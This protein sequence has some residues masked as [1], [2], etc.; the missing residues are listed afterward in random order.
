MTAIDKILVFILL[1]A[2][3]SA[4]AKIWLPSYLSDNMVLQRNSNVNIWGWT[5]DTYT[6][7]TITVTGSWNQVPVTTVADQ[8]R[9]SA[10]LAT[11]AAGGPYNILI[12]AHDTI[13]L[14][15][16]MMGDVWICFGA[17]EY[18]MDAA[19]RGCCKLKKRSNRQT[20]PK[21]GFSSCPSTS[22]LLSRTIPRVI[23]QGARPQTMQNFSS[24]SLLFWPGVAPRTGHT[25]GP[26]LLQL[27]RNT[28]RN[29]D[30]GRADLRRPGIEGGSGS[31]SEVLRVAADPR[32]NF[33]RHD[34]PP[35]EKWTSPE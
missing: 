10:T 33:Q 17:I 8:G 2:W 34:P 30:S 13:R 6:N 31:T 9:W 20:I 23:G 25:G 26:G 4:A 5:T 24:V 11:P 19:F 3:N 22:L 29:L 35:A 1:L 27:G 15:N 18:G 12:E 14:E 21:S 16:I 32:F 28:D 7:E